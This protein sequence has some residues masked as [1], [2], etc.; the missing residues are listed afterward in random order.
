MRGC[1]AKAQERQVPPET[2]VFVGHPADRLLQA[3]AAHGVDVI[4]VG[5]RGTS[6]IRESASGSTW[7]RIVT[8]ANC[9]VLVLRAR[10]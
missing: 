3:A 4:V 7:R 2:Y 1:D 9:P 8:H 10:S 5:H 6:A